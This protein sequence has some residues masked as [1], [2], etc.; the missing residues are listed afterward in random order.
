MRKAT[1]DRQIQLDALGRCR[2]QA[3][4]AVAVTGEHRPDQFSTVP[5]LSPAQSIL[6][7]RTLAIDLSLTVCG[8]AAGLPPSYHHGRCHPRLF[9]CQMTAIDLSLYG[10]LSHFWQSGFVEMR[11]DYVGKCSFKLYRIY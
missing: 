4:V 1:K 11:V 2:R 9:K 8:A 5:F 7:L 6:A 3:A 10:L